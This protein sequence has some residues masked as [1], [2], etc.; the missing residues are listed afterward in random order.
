MQFSNLIAIIFATGVLGLPSLDA[1]SNQLSKRTCWELKGEKLK[2]CQKACELACDAVTGTLAKTLC[3]KA[4]D[5]PPLKVR[6]IET[7][8]PGQLTVE[9]IET[10]SSGDLVQ[11]AKVISPEVMTT[12]ATVG[13]DACIAACEV[14]CNST[15]LALEQK[16]CLA[17]CVS[18]SSKL[19]AI[20]TS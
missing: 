14:L 13:H 19:K 11:V 15:V 16:K 2:I 1:G 20:Y 18:N 7:A 6:S 4:C 12:Q 5:A 17:K 9:D 8:T 3:K 10:A